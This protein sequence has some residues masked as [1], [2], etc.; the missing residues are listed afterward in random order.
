[1]RLLYITASF[2]YGSGETFL[3]TE[4]NELRRLDHTVLVLPVWGRGPLVHPAHGAFA[5]E[6]GVAS[7]LSWRVLWAAIGEVAR[8]PR[9]ALWAMGM[10]LG[11]GHI[12]GRIRNCVALPKALYAASIIRKAGVNHVHGYWASV[13][14][15]VAMVAAHV[16]GVSWSFTGHRWDL[17]EDNALAAK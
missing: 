16:A 10:V 11:S 7:V 9:R 12:R 17:R 4:L 2:P 5:T 6:V 13:P 14:A 3:L 1:M 8:V 15:T